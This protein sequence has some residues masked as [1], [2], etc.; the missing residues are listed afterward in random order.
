MM[1]ESTPHTPPPR[2]GDRR[3][4][5]AVPPGW[6][7]PTQPLRQQQQRPPQWSAYVIFAGIIVVVGCF[8]I[9]VAMLA[10]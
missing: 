9:L 10:R 3:H 6:N 2:S 7:Q 5:L 1:A 4:V 8:A